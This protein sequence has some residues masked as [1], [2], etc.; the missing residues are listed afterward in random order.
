[1][2]SLM[3]RKAIPAD[4]DIVK[5][6]ADAHKNEL[7]FVLRPAL[8]SSIDRGEVI[9][10]ENSRGIVGFVE[11][12][13]RQDEQTTLYHIAVAPQHRRQ[14]IGQ[15]LVNALVYDAGEHNQRFVLLKCPADLEANK[16]YERLGFSHVDTQPGKQRE[17]SIWRLPLSSAIRTHKESG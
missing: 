1:M 2:T 16:F 4:L 12:H 10:A 14:G 17:L 3:I 11:Y 5:G 13:H 7:G 15:R 8:A 9:V 6:L